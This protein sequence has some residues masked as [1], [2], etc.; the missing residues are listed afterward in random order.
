[1]REDGLIMTKESKLLLFF[2]ILIANGFY[3]LY[4][5]YKFYCHLK[6]R[7]I[8]KFKIIYLYLCLCNNKQKLEIKLEQFQKSEEHDDL[9]EQYRHSLDTLQKL[10]RKGIIS[11]NPTSVEK[12]KI[13]LD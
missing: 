5:V 9:R 6:Y 12:A 8:K 13:Y 11:L 2:V 1:M 3:L 4:W 10:P 7:L